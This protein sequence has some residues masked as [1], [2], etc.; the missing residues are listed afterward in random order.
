[1]RNF[2]QISPLWKE[3]LKHQIRTRLSHAQTQQLKK[4]VNRSVELGQW[5]RSG[6]SDQLG[7][8][9]SCVDNVFH[10]CVQKTGSQWISAVFRDLRVR[11]ASGL[12][13]FPQ[14]RY[15][16]GEFRSNFPRRT[17]VPGL[18]ISRP[19]YEEIEKPDTYKTLYVLR[20][21]RDI[22]LS[23]YWSVKETHHLMGKVVKHRERLESLS[24]HEGL[25]Y[26]I[27]TLSIKFS[28]MRSWAYARDDE[29]VLFIRLEDLAEEPVAGFAEIME[30]CKIPLST[31]QLEEIL[32]DYTKEKMRR[33]DLEVRGQDERSHYRKEST[34]WR[35]AFD[36][37]HRELFRDVTGNLLGLLGYE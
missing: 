1:M 7:K 35:Q 9:R 20:D 27:R 2:L 6:L 25:K 13:P 14:F 21:P 24:F 18:Y 37:E 29:H 4:L 16:W 19:L 10:A 28:Y 32:K 3:K 30:H 34:D 5:V 8:E 23:W 12:A 22:A 33:R 26:A 31:A 11:E 15:E 17:F 36:P